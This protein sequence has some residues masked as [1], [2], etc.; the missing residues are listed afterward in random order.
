MKNNHVTILL[1]AM[2]FLLL[3]YLLFQ[4]HKTRALTMQMVELQENIQQQHVKQTPKATPSISAPQKHAETKTS[5][6]QSPK[7]IM[8]KLDPKEVERILAQAKHDTALSEAF[9][10]AGSGSAM[11]SVFISTPED[12]DRYWEAIQFQNDSQQ[13]NFRTLADIVSK[14]DFSF[15]PKADQEAVTQFVSLREKFSENLY[16]NDVPIEEKLET[17]KQIMQLHQQ[18]SDSIQKAIEHTFGERMATYRKMHDDIF[19]VIKGTE[20]GSIVDHWYNGYRFSLPEG[21]QLES[22][23]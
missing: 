12:C 6:R 11:Q 5:A 23:Q 21:F 7:E 18:V 9:Q 19:H 17:Y 15:L 22:Q 8:A 13:R 4:I 20:L 2:A 10:K 1:A 14:L 3:A 16:D